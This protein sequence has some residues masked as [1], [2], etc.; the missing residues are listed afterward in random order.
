MMNEKIASIMTK[1]LLT[2]KADDTLDKVKDIFKRKRMHHLPV[3]D[4]TG[5]KLVGLITTGD[6]LWLNRSFDDYPSIKVEEVMTTKL[7]KLESGAKI[8][9]AAQIFLKNWFHAIPVV[10]EDG[11]LNGLVTTFDVLKYEFIKA[12]PNDQFPFL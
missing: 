12:Y 5:K 10:D 3:V 1:D 9:T 8:G 6:L 4:A 2:V 11:V 7:A